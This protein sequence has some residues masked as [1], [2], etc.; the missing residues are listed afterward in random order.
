MTSKRFELFK[1]GGIKITLDVSWIF[2]AILIAWSLS[3]GF[4]PLNYPNLSPKMYWLMGI[5]GML[6]LFICVVLHELGHSLVAKHYRLPISQITLFIFGGVAEIKKEPQKAKVEFWMAL[7]GPLVSIFI[8]IVTF[9]LATLGSQNEWPIFITGV[10]SYLALVNVALVIFNLIP[11][12]PLDGGRIFRAILWGITKDLAIATKIAT[13]LGKGFGIL[14]M[15]LGIVIVITGNLLSGLWIGV[16]GLFLRGAAAQAQVQFA[17]NQ[18]LKHEIVSQFMKKPITVSPDTTI[19]DFV[20]RIVYQSHHY[21][22]PVVESSNLVGYVSL[23]E[24]KAF[25]KKSWNQHS[26]QEIMVPLS[27]FRTVHPDTNV[28]DAMDLM[29]Q[30]NMPALFVMDGKHLVGILTLKDLSRTF[31]LKLELEK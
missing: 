28:I 23:D 14:L 19:K 12:F 22:Y 6:G 24:I 4:F 27:K 15:L 31:L 2:I 3:V 5:V 13:Q 1:I 26:I 29:N 21:T 10:L 18:S 8:A 20:D 17:L 16:I 11:A 9:F 7:A 25:P 30:M